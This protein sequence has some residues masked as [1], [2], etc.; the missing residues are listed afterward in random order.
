MGGGGGHSWGVIQKNLM[1][2][3]GHEENVSSKEIP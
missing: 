1:S 3:R 2:L